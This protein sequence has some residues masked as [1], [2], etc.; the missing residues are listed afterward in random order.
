MWL[1][2][3]NLFPLLSVINVCFVVLLQLSAAGLWVAQFELHLRHNV[4]SREDRENKWDSDGMATLGASF[5]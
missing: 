4:M 3:L 1:R 5:W 2:T